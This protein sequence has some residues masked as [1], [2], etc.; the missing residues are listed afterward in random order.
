MILFG[1]TFVNK[2]YLLQYLGS[3]FI[4]L[5]K[6][7]YNIGMTEALQHTPHTDTSAYFWQLFGDIASQ[8]S[9][10]HIVALGMSRVQLKMPTKVRQQMRAT[11]DLIKPELADIHHPSLRSAPFS[12]ILGAISF[13][14]D[15]EIFVG[16]DFAHKNDSTQLAY[17]VTRSP[18]QQAATL[19]VSLTSFSEAR[20]IANQQATLT[21]QQEYGLLAAFYE[22][23]G[24]RLE[25]ITSH[26]S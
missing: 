24:A 12:A 18:E 1:N 21:P 11:T 22:L 19:N 17:S 25:L 7:W 14:N 4:H 9:S 23:S 20:T 5:L 8:P 3:T 6:R 15:N 26:S 13:G 16:I 10:L 2:L